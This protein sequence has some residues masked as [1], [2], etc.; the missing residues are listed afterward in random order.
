MKIFNKLYKHNA[1][2]IKKNF[3]QKE[4]EKIVN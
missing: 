2:K 4:I 1:T 3:N